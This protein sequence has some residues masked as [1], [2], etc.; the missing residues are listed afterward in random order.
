MGTPCHSWECKGRLDCRNYRDDNPVIVCRLP[1]GGLQIGATGFT[2]L[3]H[4]SHG[5]STF[6]LGAG[7]R[8][9]SYRRE[10]QHA[11]RD[12]FHSH[13]AGG[14]QIAMEK[15]RAGYP[16]LCTCGIDLRCRFSLTVARSTIPSVPM[17]MPSSF[18]PYTCLACSP[19]TCGRCPTT[20]VLGTCGTALSC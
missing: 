6:C 18:P 8:P 2:C 14:S 5:C 12:L 17:P 3:V 7:W 11:K 19:C 10:R 16:R 20:S 15:A 9:G 13:I 4:G 1:G